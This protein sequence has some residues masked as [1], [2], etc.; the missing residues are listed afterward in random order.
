MRSVEKK[1]TG[2]SQRAEGYPLKEGVCRD[3]TAR[4][5]KMSGMNEELANYFGTGVSEDELQKQAQAEMFLKL[6]EEE[7][8]DIDQLSDEQVQE[9]YDA[10]FSDEGESVD[11]SI[12]EQA[13]QE[14]AEKQAAA[15]KFAEAEFMGRTMAHAYVNELQK[16]AESSDPNAAAYD[17][18]QKALK[19]N[20][21]GMGAE[22]GAAKGGRGR[23]VGGVEGT[24][25]EL[26]HKGKISIGGGLRRLGDTV[27]GGRLKNVT[28]TGQGQGQIFTKNMRKNRRATLAGMGAV[29]GGTVLA[30]GAAYG[31]KK[32][33]DKSKEKKAEALDIMAANYALQKIA[34]SEMFDVDEAASRLEAVLILDSG[35]SE[36]T[37]GI[38]DPDDFMEIRSLELAEMA[39]YP[40]E[41]P[42][43]Q[44]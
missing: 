26:G 32:M 16:I 25:R 3:F 23:A 10:T 40:V 12:Q 20:S 21:R 13:A 44:D 7:G 4:R 35:E 36:K 24:V 39:G 9:L 29:A 15:E 2:D 22:R 31:A 28:T 8:I 27:S 17:K 1:G 5:F 38:V 34:A 19:A 18:K 41:W 11:N 42:E 6:A 30:G 33:Y 14:F 43:Y 37:A